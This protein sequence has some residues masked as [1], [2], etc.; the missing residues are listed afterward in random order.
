M[1]ATPLTC[2]APRAGR[3]AE[4]LAGFGGVNWRTSPICGSCQT[5]FAFSNFRASSARRP[6]L[7]S[8]GETISSPTTR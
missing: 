6:S 8:P 1:R 2:T 7:S 4:E 5:A 3:A